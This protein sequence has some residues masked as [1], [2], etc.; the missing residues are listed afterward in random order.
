MTAYLF[1]PQ[2][3]DRIPLFVSDNLTSN[4]EDEIRKIEN[5]ISMYKST[6]QPTSEIAQILINNFDTIQGSTLM[7]ISETMM[8]EYS[9]NTNIRGA[10]MKFV[11]KFNS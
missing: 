1:V 8:V 11:E 7:Y 10:L 4:M 3:D 5:L 2:R 6:D 9:G